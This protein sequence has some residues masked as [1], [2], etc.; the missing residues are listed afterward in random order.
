MNPKLFAGRLQNLLTMAGLIGV[1]P[2]E[3]DKRDPQIMVTNQLRTEAIRLE[4]EKVMRD[5]NQDACPITS[6]GIGVQRPPMSKITQ[7]LQAILENS[8]LLLA[9]LI[10]DKPH[11]TSIVLKTR[12]V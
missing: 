1:V 7:S 12:M 9:A 5:L 4:P 2:R 11:T 10:G 6:L 3:K 8:I